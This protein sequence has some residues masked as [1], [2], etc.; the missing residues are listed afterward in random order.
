M[1][2]VVKMLMGGGKRLKNEIIRALS[3]SIVNI[4]YGN[5]WRLREKCLSSNKNK[6]KYAFLYESY[7]EHYGAWI[8]LGAKFD[9]IPI[10][11]HGYHG[12]FISN[13]AHIGKNVV[14]FHQVT[15]GSNMIKGSRKIGAPVIEDNVYIGCG[16]KI[17][18]ALNV[19]HNARIGANAIVVNDVPSNSV[20]VTKGTISTIKTEPLDNEWIINNG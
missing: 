17:I 3:V 16:A 13:A 2:K 11:P 12:I 7:F 1:Q 14:I 19:G 4:V 8:G 10:F 18:G 20:T 6:A 5:I 9:G 15:I